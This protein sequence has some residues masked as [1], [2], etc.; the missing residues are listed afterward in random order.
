[1]NGKQT[2]GAGTAKIGSGNSY[3]QKK[4]EHMSFDQADTSNEV[5]VSV[6]GY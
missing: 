3:T 2:L 5:F 6:V 1:M 4:Y